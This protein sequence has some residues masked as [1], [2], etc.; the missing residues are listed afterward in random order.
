MRKDIYAFLPFFVKPEMYSKG[1]PPV[2][3]EI[4]L[5]AGISAFFGAVLAII[6]VDI[7]EPGHALQLLG[8][9]IVGLLTG[10]GVYAKQRLDD[11][12]TR[13]RIADKKERIGE[14]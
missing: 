2:K 7:L 9:L 1:G 14:E 11:A 3:H 8:A 5:W 10:G 13:Q 6:T 12:K 4:A